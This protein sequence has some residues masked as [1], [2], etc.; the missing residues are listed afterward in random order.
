MPRITAFQI[1]TSCQRRPPWID[2][3]ETFGQ[4][5][6]LLLIR[7]APVPAVSDEGSGVEPDHIVYVSCSPF[8]FAEDIKEA[9]AFGYRLKTVQPVDPF[10]IQSMLN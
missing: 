9:H 5:D 6:L 7:P 8:T 1:R 3:F 2:E 4:P 10:L